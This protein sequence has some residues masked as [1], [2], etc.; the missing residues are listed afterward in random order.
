MCVS[1][2]V[3]VCGGRGR[4]S[5]PQ[6]REREGGRARGLTLSTIPNYESYRWTRCF[7]RLVVRFRVYR[8]SSG[9]PGSEVTTANEAGERHYNQ[10]GALGGNSQGANQPRTG[11]SPGRDGWLAIEGRCRGAKAA[12]KRR[13]KLAL[14]DKGATSDDVIHMEAANGRLRRFACISP[15]YARNACSRFRPT[16]RQ[17]PWQPW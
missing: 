1:V 5:P 8:D 9:S 7:S 6:T 4:A 15:A 17:Q 10:K 3:C 11:D 13:R 16:K 2:R 12:P 14:G